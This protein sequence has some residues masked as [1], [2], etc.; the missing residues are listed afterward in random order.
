[1]LVPQGYDLKA[2]KRIGHLGA[3]F[4][5]L[6]PFV[7]TKALEV[8]G[9]RHLTCG[10]KASKSTLSRIKDTVHPRILSRINGI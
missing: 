8:G 5:H 10:I 4:S 7:P 2:L 1:M 6:D 9:L 3:V